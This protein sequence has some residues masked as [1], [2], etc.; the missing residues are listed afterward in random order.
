MLRSLVVEFLAH[1]ALVVESP[2]HD[3]PGSLAHVANQ[4]SITEPERE[5][6]GFDQVCMFSSHM[7]HM[8]MYQIALTLEREDIIHMKTIPRCNIEYLNFVC[9]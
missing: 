5:K 7:S 9:L 1:A 6:K 8:L 4:S 2:V 3:V